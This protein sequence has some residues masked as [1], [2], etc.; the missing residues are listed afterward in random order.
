MSSVTLTDRQLA[1]ARSQLGFYLQRFGARLKGKN[2][3]YVV[4]A[5]R[6][7]ESLTG[8][9]SQM[10][11]KGPAY[12][13][14]ANV[15]DM[16]AGK[17]MDQVNLHKLLQ[18]LQESKLARKVHGYQARISEME[19]TPRAKV[20]QTTSP[21]LTSVQVFLETLMNLASEGRFFCE[22]AENG[23]WV[24]RYMLLDPSP[25]FREVV[26]DA[27]AVILAGGTMSPVRNP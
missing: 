27:R 25:Y 20:N 12:E 6:V 24:L 23:D 2:R 9:I 14:V 10:E 16:M 4:Q 21:V 7:I 8:Y 18:Y 22:K 13:G 3:V 11:E 17:G 26:E 1:A 15:N 19:K 5:V